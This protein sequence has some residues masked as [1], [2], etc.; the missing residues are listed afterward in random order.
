MT[1]SPSDAPVSHGFIGGIKPTQA[2]GSTRTNAHSTTWSASSTGVWET[3]LAGWAHGATQLRGTE[4]PTGPT[5]DTHQI[6]PVGRDRLSSATV[7]LTVISRVVSAGGTLSGCA[8]R[9]TLY[10]G[11]P[12]DLTLA[13]GM[14]SRGHESSR[15]EAQR[16]GAALAD[17][18]HLVEAARYPS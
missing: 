18:T 11:S 10:R 7:Y 13:G 15:R 17:R 5:S 4:V 8:T 16:I 14:V 9:S 12:A 6:W 3:P 2:M 1:A